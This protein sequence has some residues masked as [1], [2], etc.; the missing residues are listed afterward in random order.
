MDSLWLSR[1]VAL[2]GRLIGGTRWCA[3]AI[4]VARRASRERVAF[5]RRGLLRA[6][7][8]LRVCSGG[9]SGG[10]A[11]LAAVL[12]LVLPVDDDHVTAVDASGQA[13]AVA[14][15]LRYGDVL[16]FGG[17]AVLHDVDVR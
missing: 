17:V 12:Q 1:G 8:V 10:R 6:S 5:L 2:L 16:D 13:D 14:A 4:L 3:A 15:G 11:D 9:G 7:G